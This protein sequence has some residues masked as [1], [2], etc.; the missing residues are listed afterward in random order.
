MFSLS[1]SHCA[2]EAVQIRAF[3]S[4]RAGPQRIRPEAAGSV[5]NR[6]LHLHDGDEHLGPEEDAALEHF[7]AM[8]K[9]NPNDNQGIRYLLLAGLL[10]RDDLSGAKALLAAYGDEW[11]ANWLYT[12]ALIAFRENAGAKPATLKLLKDARSSNEHVPAILA[13]IKPPVINDSGYVTMGGPDEATYY[14][15]E[16]GKAWKD[17]CIDSG[18]GSE[19]EGKTGGAWLP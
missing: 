17:A 4:E 14:V 18:A 15:L 10:R 19:A 5:V 12:R 3:T 8:L 7:R 1:Q 2:T 9:L 11:S 6:E 13:G 16:F